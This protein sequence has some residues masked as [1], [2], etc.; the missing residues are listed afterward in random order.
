[1]RV[2]QSRPTHQDAAGASRVWSNDVLPVGLPWLHAVHGAAP[3][4]EGR[5]R[6]ALLLALA[7]EQ[8]WLRMKFIEGK[9]SENEKAFALPLTDARGPPQC[10]SLLMVDFNR[11]ALKRCKV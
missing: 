11:M 10:M 7:H 9:G 1:M 4:S 8:S 5:G 6:E 2:G 3:R